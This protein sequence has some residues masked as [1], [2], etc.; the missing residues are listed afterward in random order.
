LKESDGSL[1]LDIYHA[2][3]FQ[4][5][6]QLKFY[7]AAYADFVVWN[8]SQLFIQRV[9]P[10]EP[11]MSVVLEQCKSFIKIGVLPELIGKYYSKDPIVNNPDQE[12]ISEIAENELWCYCQQPDGDEEM[13]ACDDKLS[14]CFKH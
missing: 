14:K 3:Y 13:I 5:Q 11:F 2:Y 8:E 6:A 1:A 9:Y 10:D 7:S 4:V 12:N